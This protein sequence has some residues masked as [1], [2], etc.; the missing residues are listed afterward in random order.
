[1]MESGGNRRIKKRRSIRLKNNVRDKKKD[2]ERRN[3]GF[4]IQK[5]V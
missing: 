1:M 3:V 2:S 4:K 5:L